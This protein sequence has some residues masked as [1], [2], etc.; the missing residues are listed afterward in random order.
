MKRR[1][2]LKCSLQMGALGLLSMLT[3]LG[4]DRMQAGKAR[5]RLPY[6]PDALAPYISEETISFHFGQHHQ[7][8]ADRVLRLSAGTPYTGHTLKSIIRETAAKPDWLDLHRNASQ[9]YNHG[10]YWQSMQ[11]G[12]GG[13]PP[14]ALE[15]LIKRDFGSLQ[16]FSQLFYDRATGVW[17]SGWVWLVEDKGRLSVR[18][19]KNEGTPLATNVTPILVI[20]MWEHAYYLDYQNRH[21]RYVTAFLEQLINWDFAARNLSHLM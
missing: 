11:P 6:E 21:D 15:R 17:G 9:A 4:C 16:K 20:D 10:F 8:Y 1:D 2:F 12:G 18:S 14:N 7:G 3:P 13:N 19:T 5:L